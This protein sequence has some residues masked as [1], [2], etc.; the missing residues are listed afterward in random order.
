MGVET[1][2]ELTKYFSKTLPSTDEKPP[3][4]FASDK[5]TMKRKTG[6]IAGVITPDVEAPLSEPLL[7][8]VFL[9]M[10]VTRHHDGESIATQMLSIMDQYLADVEEQVQSICN[11]GQYIHLN[12]KKHM[13]ELRKELQ[14][15]SEWILFSHD[16][17]HR[18]NLGSN[19]AT[20]DNRDKTKKAGS[21][22]EV[23][24]LVQ[25]IN[26]HVLYGKHN[27][28]LEAILKD[29]GITDKNKPLTFS[30][31]RFPQYA[32]F[33]LRNVINSYP[34]LIKQMEYELSYTD[35]KAEDLKDTMEQATDLEFVVKVVGATDIFRRQQIMSQQSQKVDQ[36]ISDVFGNLKTQ[37]DKEKTMNDNLKSNKHPNDWDESDV[38]KL[39]EHLWAETRKAL[40][41]IITKQTYKNIKLK[42]SDDLALAVAVVELRNHLNRNIFAL[43]ERFE[44]YFSS[45]FV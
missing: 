24:E 17:A 5:M 9:A 6:H 15:K 41:E 31:T 26:K 18:I 28:E 8:P 23:F 21:L 44:A 4:S 32:Y 29:I 13:M 1:Q 19:D 33:V 12:I 20:K 16:P 30:D 43:E 7:K 38:L 22:T 37:V 25:K 45:D 34:A 39:D 35:G 27:L 3:V 11:D 14:D 10:P 40:I 42:K 36:L 2:I